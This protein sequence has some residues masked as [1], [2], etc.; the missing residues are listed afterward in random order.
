MGKAVEI[1]ETAIQQGKL[2][3][4]WGDF[5]VD[6]QTSTTLLVS[7]LKELGAKVIFHIPIRATE[8]HGIN[9][10]NLEPLVHDGVQV[11]LTCDTGISSHEAVTYAREQGLQVVITDHHDLPPSLPDA[12]AIINSKMLP[13]DHPLSALPGVGVAYKLIEELYLRQDRAE[14]LDKFLDLVALGIV[15]DVALLHGDTRYLLQ[16]GLAILRQTQRL[17]LQTL[18]NTADLHANQITESQIGFVIGPRLNALGRLGDANLI[19]EFLTTQDESRARIIS[20]Q[21]EGLNAQRKLLTKQVFEGALAKIDKDPSLLKHS[22]LVLAHENWPAGVVGIVASRL[23]DRFNK[24]VVLISNPPGEKA[25]GSARSIENCDISQAIAACSDLL[26]GFG[27]HPMAAGLSLDSERIDQF[28]KRLSD[29]VSRQLGDVGLEPELF[30]DARLSLEDLSMT[31]LEQIGQLSP[32]G[33]G[34]P[35]LHFASD[36]L[37]LVSH[38]PLGRTEEHLRLIIEDEVGNRHKVLWWNGAGWDLP[39]GKFDL[40]YTAN[41]STFQDERELQVEL[42][43]YRITD[44]GVQEEDTQ[45]IIIVD[46]RGE[47]DHE[48]VLEK[49]REQGE[50]LIVWA[51]AEEKRRVG[52]LDRRE[53]KPSDTLVLWNLPPSYSIV[54]QALKIVQPKKVYVVG[55]NSKMDHLQ[56]FLKRLTG[57]LKYSISQKGGQVHLDELASS[58]SQTK[59]AVRVGISWLESKGY[60]TVLQEENNVILISEPDEAYNPLF[61]PEGMQ[62]DLK[63]LL[64]E[65]SLFRKHLSSCDLDSLVNLFSYT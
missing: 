8:S 5:D 32:F 48:G 28:R 60:V 57:L 16:R 62:A 1:L 26:E 2:I 14:A 7:A 31:F 49:I 4:V 9:L 54:K 50:D 46:Y 51:E 30:V 65:S 34:N 40:A 27:G 52:G 25:R 35:V 29:E 10:P 59:A 12:D 19:V 43:D 53:L 37:R 58:T 17:G 56:E 21:L 55:I 61:S 15:A 64:K 13:T 22:A 41:I 11:L 18:F 39:Q 24:P 3:G 36:N 44:E 6:G 23:V 20:N 38:S 63:L 47:K 45:D 42:V 33:P